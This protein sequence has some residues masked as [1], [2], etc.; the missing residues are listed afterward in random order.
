[1]KKNQENLAGSPYR[2]KCIFEGIQDLVPGLF[3]RDNVK[4]TF[5]SLS[6]IYKDFTIDPQN[7]ENSIS[8]PNKPLSIIQ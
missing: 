4:T 6:A 2:V 8:L 3:G 7:Y 1:M 5:D